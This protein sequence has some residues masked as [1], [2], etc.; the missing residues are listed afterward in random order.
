MGTDFRRIYATAMKSKD[1]PSADIMAKL[2]QDSSLK[3]LG[4]WEILRWT[5]GYRVILSAKIPTD[6]S[7]TTLQA[8]IRFV[9]FGAD[10]ME[11]QLTGK[12][13]F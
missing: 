9:L 12:D 1:L 4:A 2:L 5:D 10:E 13:E 8:T 7:S 3:K 6:C 11:D